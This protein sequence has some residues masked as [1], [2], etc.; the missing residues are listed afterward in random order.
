MKKFLINVNGTSYNV[1]V[2]EIKDGVT[3]APSAPSAAPA[4][5][6]APSAAP[7]AASAAA[8]A[9]PK[10]AAVV[11]EGGTKV[12]SPMPGT[13]SGINV[14]PGDTV[15]KGTVLLILE[16]MKMQNEIMAAGDGTVTAV[17]VTNGEVASTGQVLVILN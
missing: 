14:K 4:M 13:I 7:S 9:A 11:P 2:E 15:K 6:A 10:A 8:P 16:A 17:L 1:D 12:T 3:M 5:A